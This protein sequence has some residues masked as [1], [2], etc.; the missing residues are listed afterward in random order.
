MKRKK[1]ILM[2]RDCKGVVLLVDGDRFVLEAASMLLGMHG[3]RVISS[4][5]SGEAVSVLR[6]GDVEVVIADIEMERACGTELLEAARAVRPGTPVLLMSGNESMDAAL[7][8]VKNGAFDLILKP[9]RPEYLLVKVERAMELS[10]L[11]NIEK[12]YN[13]ALKDTAGRGATDPAGA[14][15][16]HRAH[17]ESSLEM[18]S[19]LAG[20]A[21]F[22]DA[23]PVRPISRVGI[24]AGL[25]AEQMGMDPGFVEAVTLASPMHDIGKSGISDSILLKA[26]PLS[27]SEF[28]TMKTHTMIGH[29]LL[30][31]SSHENIRMAATIAL[32]H[33]E[34]WDGS[35]YPYGLKGDEIPLEGM[36]AMLCDRYDALR[37]WRPY[38]AALGHPASVGIITGGNER[39]RPAHFHPLVLEAFKKLAPEFDEIFLAGRDCE[40]QSVEQALVGM[41]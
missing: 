19:R 14:I 23:A 39:S 5:N 40:E 32:T 9:Y 38:K 18:V 25:V 4:D 34:C 6:A 24:C 30:E 1:G 22:G 26:G 33:H 29:R 11:L 36:I 28:E 16:E 15:D 7:G 21:E 12:S 2:D 37:S 41:N 10:R 13:D 31:G 3:Y 27:P 8:A 17:R 35:G 20:A